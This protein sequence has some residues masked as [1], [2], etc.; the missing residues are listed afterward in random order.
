MGTQRE[1]SLLTSAQP[2]YGYDQI[3]ERRRILS[4][5]NP[6]V[7]SHKLTDRDRFAKSRRRPDIM[8]FAG[9]RL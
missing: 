7:L 1:V 6:G 5:C 4:D 2:L 9:Q 3:L 8:L